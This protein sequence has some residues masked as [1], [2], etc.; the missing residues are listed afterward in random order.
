LRELPVQP[1]FQLLNDT[2]AKFPE[3]AAI[4]MKNR[5]YTYRQL[6]EQVDRFTTALVRLGLKKGDRVAVMFR[7]SPEYVIAYYAALQAGGVVVQVNPLYT[8]HELLYILQHSGAAWALTSGEQLDKWKRVRPQTVIQSII[9]FG[10]NIPVSEEWIYEA[11][12]LIASTPPEPP[13]VNIDAMEDLAVLQYT[14][15]TTGRSKGVMLTH[16]NLVANV[17]QSYLFSSSLL[18]V[19]GEV[20]LGISPFYHVYGMTSCMNLTL[21]IAGTLIPL[22]RFDADEVIDTIERERPTLF[23]GVPTMYIAL[24]HHEKS[25]KTDMSSLKLCIS[26]S[27]PLPVEIMHQFEAKTGARIVEG[28]G[29]SEA[30]PV[31]HRNPVHGLRKEGS[32][33]VPFPFTEAKIVDL[34]TGTKEVPPGEPGEL[35]IRGP[36]V[37]KGYW[38]DEEATRIALR[39]GWLYTGDIATKDEDGYFYLVGRKKELI[40]TGGFNV[41]PKEIEEVLYEYPKVKEAAVVGVPDPYRGEAVKAF[42]VPKEGE[43]ICAEELLRHCKNRLTPYKVPRSIEIRPFLPKT[44][45]G[46]ILK[47][48]LVEETI[49]PCEGEPRT[50][51]SK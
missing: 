23:S 4:R 6:K 17:H 12:K 36:Q 5:T 29:L 28:Y 41:Y 27:A 31:T 38:N 46:K 10:S 8:D 34:E 18:S 3:R 13:R 39:D 1:V 20:V 51:L 43:I 19:P 7:N 16:F 47:R 37:M 45:V 49:R 35:L 26:G 44:S 30:S 15:G 50:R 40:I 48:M 24:L 11:E 42:V 2:A 14:G 9:L 33:G 25:A 22:E 32:I 21:Y